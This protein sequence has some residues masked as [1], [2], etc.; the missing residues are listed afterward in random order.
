MQAQTL[1]LYFD[2][3]DVKSVLH[4]PQTVKWSECS[5]VRVFPRGDGSQPPA[6]T[7]LPSVIEKSNRSVIVHGLGVSEILIRVERVGLMVRR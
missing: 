7:V 1:P 3:S 4:A 5:N 6:F 2:R